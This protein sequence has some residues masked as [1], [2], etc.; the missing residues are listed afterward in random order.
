M[1]NYSL[2]ISFLS[3]Y[4]KLAMITVFVSLAAAILESIGFSLILPIIS[5]LL[6]SENQSSNFFNLKK[7]KFLNLLENLNMLLPILLILVFL[8]RTI[9]ILTNIYL[10]NYLSWS[11]RSYYANLLMQKYLNSF[12]ESIVNKKTGEI[13]NATLTETNRAAQAIRYLIEFITKTFLLIALL[14]LLFISNFYLATSIICVSLIFLFFFK[15]IISNFSTNIGQRRLMLSQEH[16]EKCTEL[17]ES[18]KDSKILG[19]ESELLSSFDG[20]V[21]KYSKINILFTFVTSTPQI[22]SEFILILILG[23]SMIIISLLAY[24]VN[25]ILPILAL[26]LTVSVRLVQTISAML[27][28]RMKYLSLIPSVNKVTNYV[29]EDLNQEHSKGRLIQSIDTDINVENLDFSYGKNKKIFNRINCTIKKNNFTGI[30]G[31]SGSGKSTFVNI[32]T[33][34]LFPTNGNI[35]VNGLKLEDININSW[36]NQIGYVNQSPFLFNDTIYNNILFGRLD[37]KESEII[38]ACKMANAHTFI[39]ELPDKYE[40]LVGQRGGAL[41]G[42]QLQR[43]AIARAILRRPS[44]FIFDECTSALDIESEKSIIK[45]IEILAKNFSIIVITH[46]LGNI[47]NADKIYEIKNGNIKEV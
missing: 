41:S 1:N 3:K 7:I 12:F 45:T 28:L 29:N 44:L 46:K 18:I 47:K 5:D 43:I 38:D 11:L 30:I 4:K 10:T 17:I 9:L 22:L 42:G 20:S 19:L 34:L 15:K 31:D 14:I 8:I 6:A 26:Y 40:T 25:S 16:T 21:Q 39:N 36:R 37:A 13:L 35:S 32:L 24:D 23:V 27:M 33:A 2:I